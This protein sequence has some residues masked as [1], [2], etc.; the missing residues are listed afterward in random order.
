MR[1]LSI[2]TAFAVVALL[3]A[4]AARGADGAAKAPA[5]S[6]SSGGAP[7]KPPCPPEQVCD[8]PP[9]ACVDWIGPP[10]DLDALYGQAVLLIF[11]E[12]W[13]PK[14]NEWVDKRAREVQDAAMRQPATII[15][16]GV[17]MNKGD[18]QRYMKQMKLEGHAAGIVDKTFAATCGLRSTLWNIV[19]IDAKGRRA[20]RGS[21]SNY[22][23]R[24]NVPI[25]STYANEMPKYCDGSALVVEKPDTPDLQKADLAVRLGKYDTAAA[26]LKK[27]GDV[28]AAALVRLEE[29]AQRTLDAARAY[30]ASDSYLAWRLAN[31][32]SRQYKSSPLAAEARVLAG[33]LAGDAAVRNGKAADTAVARVLAM[34]KKPGQEGAAVTMFAQ[35]G[36]KFSDCRGGRVAL[37]AIGQ[38]TDRDKEPLYPTEQK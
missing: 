28:G 9:L 36:M 35:V 34:T 33:K 32:L 20:A 3:V 12:S 25:G 11:V 5:S 1:R 31:A 30:Q 29:R 8:M 16:L 14:C 18:L 22:Q 38:S 17:G 26:L 6:S 13:C 21:F 2:V 23:T 7:P 15:Y 4:G 10:V 27:A 19:V 24:N 37:R